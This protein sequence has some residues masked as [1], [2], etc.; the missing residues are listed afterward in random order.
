MGKVDKLPE[1]QKVFDFLANIFG[2]ICRYVTDADICAG[3]TNEY[4]VI[5]IESLLKKVA[6]PKQFC[7]L[8]SFCSQ[9]K[10]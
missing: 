7:S 6:E 3:V 9:Y 5:L 4:G 10:V 1:N 8:H 2:Y